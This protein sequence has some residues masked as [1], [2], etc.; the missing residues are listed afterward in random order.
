MQNGNIIRQF[1]NSDV[2]EKLNAERYF[3]KRWL[4]TPQLPSDKSGMHRFVWDLRYNRPPALKY[5][6]AISGLW[7]KGTPLKPQGPLVLP[8]TYVVTLTVDGKEYNQQ[9]NVKMDPRVDVT[10]EELKQQLEFAQNIGGVLRHVF[11]AHSKVDLLL[12]DSANTA[13][14][15]IDSLKIYKAGI[16]TLDGVFASLVTS[17]QSADASPTQGQK[18][19][20]KEYL[21]TFQKLFL[22]LQKILNLY[23]LKM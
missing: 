7:M 20:F 8:G 22:R 19:L 15:I 12:K 2:P 13:R 6:Y 14:E 11:D 1:S 5:D 16:T 4:G 17:V 18:E 9:L 23:K 3:D 10:V 21:E